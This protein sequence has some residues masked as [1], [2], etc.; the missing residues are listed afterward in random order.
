MLAEDDVWVPHAIEVDG[1]IITIFD[2]TVHK[3]VTNSQA[4]NCDARWVRCHRPAVLV[5]GELTVEMLDLQFNP[6]SKFY[7]GPVQLKANNGVL[8]ID[9]FGRQRIRPEEILNRWIVPLD[10]EWISCRCRAAKSS[11][12]PS[13]CWSSSLR[14]LPV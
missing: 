12:F 9:D 1:Q 4:R 10:R 8:I 14:T 2:P 6:I 13:K 7:V 11:K 3:P 5:G